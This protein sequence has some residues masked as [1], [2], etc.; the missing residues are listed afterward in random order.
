[1]PIAERVRCLESALA[2][3][4][5]AVELASA[6]LVRARA[7]SA[8]LA[9][10]LA[11]LKKEQADQ[12]QANQSKP[13]TCGPPCTDVVVTRLDA[14]LKRLERIEKRLGTLEETAR[15]PAG[16]SGA[17]DVAPLPR[18]KRPAVFR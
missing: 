6:A 12:Q 8:K 17:D 9:A 14:I 18:P 16:P 3:Q 13:S 2:A 11:R 5:K 7:D 1:V 4:A 10:E 15:P